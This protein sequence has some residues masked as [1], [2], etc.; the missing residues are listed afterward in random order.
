MIAVYEAAKKYDS[1]R[2]KQAKY[3][4]QDWQGWWRTLFCV[5]DLMAARGYITKVRANSNPPR[6]RVVDRAGKIVAA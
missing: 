1:L 4:V 6:L 2:H 3:K 5:E